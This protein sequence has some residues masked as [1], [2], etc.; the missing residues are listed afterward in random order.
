LGHPQAVVAAATKPLAERSDVEKALLRDY[1]GSLEPEFWRLRKE[2]ADA[3]VPVAVDGR[4]TELKT[5]LAKVSEPIVLDPL[6]V[7]LRLD[8]EASK[9]Q[10]TNKRLTVVQDLTWALINNPAFL[11]NR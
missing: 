9:K 2:M 4:E 8:A 5:A 10:A 11:F 6:L 3:K 1:V 7:Q